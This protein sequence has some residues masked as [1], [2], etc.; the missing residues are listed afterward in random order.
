MYRYEVH[1]ALFTGQVNI[2]KAAKDSKI[3]L[4][5]LQASFREFC[6]LNPV[7]PD[8]WHND[9]EICWPWR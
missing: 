2:A 9:I 1:M 6:A 3:P 7:D 4:A 5:D 8:E